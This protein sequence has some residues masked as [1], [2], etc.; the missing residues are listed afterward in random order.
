[1]K[2]IRIT[3]EHATRLAHMI[4]HK[5][6]QHEFDAYIERRT[7]LAEKLYAA[8]VPPEVEAMLDALPVV[9]R[10]QKS[11]SLFIKIPRTASDLP[12]S[13]E[14]HIRFANDAYKYVPAGCIMPED[15]DESLG[16]E[17]RKCIFDNKDLIDR[18]E[19]MIQDLRFNIEKARTTKALI[20][21][22][23]EVGPIVE[24]YYGEEIT[25]PE[26][27]LEAILARYLV[28]Q[29]AAPVTAEG[30]GGDTK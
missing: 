16:A 25:E 4:A 15:V 17:I 8:L 30:N 7:V 26:R 1:M 23:P 13:S 11:V 27:P 28:P 5:A 6:I 9:Y 20:E 14:T 10:P 29:I 24:E 21:L 2:S 3:P 22:W 18:R 19:K 12:Y